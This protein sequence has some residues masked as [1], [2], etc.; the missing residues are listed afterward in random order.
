MDADAMDRMI[1]VF[2]IFLSLLAFTPEMLA[3]VS[4]LGSNPSVHDLPSS[5]K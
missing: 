5:V 3:A 1:V 4:A 2:I